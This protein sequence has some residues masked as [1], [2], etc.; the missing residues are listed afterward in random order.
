MNPAR[1]QRLIRTALLLATAFVASSAARADFPFPPSPREVHREVHGVVHDVLRSLGRI[2]AEI[3]RDHVR[4]LRT[5]YAGNAY[6]GPHRHSHATYNFPVWVGGVVDYRPYVY[7][8]GRLY[9]TYAAR[10]QLWSG[11]GVASQGHWCGHHHAYYP[12]GHA[13][14]RPQRHGSYRPPYR[15]HSGAQQHAP[16]PSHHGSTSHGGYGHGG[17]GGHGGSH[18]HDRNCHHDRGHDRH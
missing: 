9:G 17:H 13:C 15:P 10:P 1:S 5:F 18:R 2:P 3:H 7:C 14:F 11:W 16:Y 8:N 4:H 12:T 6:Y